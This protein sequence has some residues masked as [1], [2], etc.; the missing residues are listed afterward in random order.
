MSDEARDRELERLLES[1][2]PPRPNT[3]FRGRVRERFLA[4]ASAAPPVDVWP[5]EQR[6]AAGARAGRN[7][8]PWIALAAA[9]G[10]AIALYLA[11]PAPQPWRVLPGSSATTVRVDGEALPAADVD[12]IILALAAARSVG[13]EGGSL[14]LVFRDQ[15]AFEIPAG[16]R[17]DFADPY[18]LTAQGPALRVVTGPGFPGHE[19]RVRSADA[20]L[21]VTGTA[22][23]VDNFP[24]GVCVCGLEGRIALRDQ[25]SA[26]WPLEAG[27]QCFVPTAADPP[28]W[29]EARDPHVSPV[30]DL[31]AAAR[32]HW[33]P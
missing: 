7:W 9:A 11:K 19:L 14:R 33:Q 28:T 30:R 16:A 13:A 18:T 3:E 10:V 1:V 22:F 17:V 5:D 25:D 20:N 31:E 6:H 2:P 27:K 32:G 24:E 26:E 29:G 4:G 21:R 15:Y 23:A 8:K 12:R